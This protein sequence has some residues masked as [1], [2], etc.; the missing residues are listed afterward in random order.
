VRQVLYAVVALGTVTLIGSRRLARDRLE[1]ALDEAATLAEEIEAR[2]ARLELMLAASGTGFWEWDIAT[3]ELV[4]SDAIFAQHGL[5]PG[6]DPPPFEAYLQMLHPDDRA[7]FQR[8]IAEAL[9]D[10]RPFDTEFRI[11]WSDGSIHWTRGSARVFRDQ[12]GQPVRMLGTGQDITERRRIE[13]E[14]DELL[15]EERRAAEFREAFI[16]VIS[17]ELRT[18]VTTILGAAQILARSERARDGSP[19]DSLLDDIH[20]EAERLHRLVEDLLVL[21]RAERGRLVIDA[22]PLAVQRLV[23]RVVAGIGPEL[24]T[25]DITVDVPVGLPIVSGEATYVEQ[26]LR[27]LL[28]NAA[29]YSPAGT[30]VTVQA[31]RQGDGVAL[32]VLDSGPGIPE[33]SETR[34]FDLF[35]RSPELARVVAGSGIGLFVCKSLVEA[36]G[37]RIWAAR[38]PQGGAEFG[39]SL[40]I[41]HGDD[42]EP[43]D[44]DHVA[45]PWASGA[46]DSVVSTRPEAPAATEEAPISRPG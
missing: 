39:F 29:K 4:W 44:L 10:E 22:E 3:G 30:A 2:D 23:E 17:H 40:R 11:V 45:S 28:G 32:R 18:P 37:G 33:G 7:G 24:P 42:E 8:A 41:L 35:Y 26:V 5:A 21:T 9:A 13:D 14:R 16:D 34:L 38:R 25:I 20:L 43:H 27:N 15:A 36:M 6:G 19:R 1:D 46:D 31:T 12:D